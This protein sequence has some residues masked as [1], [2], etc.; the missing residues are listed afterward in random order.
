MLNK[1][2]LQHIYTVFITRFIVVTL[3]FASLVF[4]LNILEEIK[5]FSNNEDINIGFP[6][7]LTFLNL[8]SVLYEIFP[9]IILITTQF[10]FLKFKDNS[11]IL[12]FKNNG[13]NNLKIISYLILLVFF[14]GLI[15]VFFFHLLSSSM[16]HSYLEIKNK[17]TQDNKYLAVINDNGLWIKDKIE[18]KTIIIHAEQ[19]DKNILKNLVITTF[20]ESFLTDQSIIAKEAEITNEEWNLQDVILIKSD[21]IKQQYNVIKFKTNFDYAKIN[22]LFS[23]LDSLNIFELFKQKRDFSSVGLSVKDIDI[24]LN[25]IFSLPI[26]LVIYLVL[27]SILMLN[28]NQGKSKIFFLIIGILLSVIL[29]YIYFFF[30]LLGSSNKVPTIFAIWLPN[31]ILFLGCIIGL[32]NINEK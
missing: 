26:S 32:V 24:Y 17:Y 14:I 2:Y 10:F 20:D 11:E 5:F 8:P 29:Y 9:F 4:V 15:I 30:G 19:I 31:L 21:G 25:K 22:T 18:N 13:I 23:N 16:K 3:I 12:I 7:F 1:I 6:I 28:I 27:S